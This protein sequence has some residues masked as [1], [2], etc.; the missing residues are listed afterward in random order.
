MKYAIT[1]PQGRIR[2][3]LD[4]ATD[5]TTPITN[6]NAALVESGVGKDPKVFYAIY[7][8]RFMEVDEM[9]N[10]RLEERLATLP[11]PTSLANWRVKAILE[12]TGHLASVESALDSMPDSNEKKIIV[13]A[14][15]GNGEVYRNSPTVTTLAQLL[16]LSDEDVDDLFRQASRFNP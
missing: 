1:G 4:E 3:V 14:W 10:L 8:D 6:A 15:R 9:R 5:E 7:N 2:R 13:N 12:I 11:P 16:G